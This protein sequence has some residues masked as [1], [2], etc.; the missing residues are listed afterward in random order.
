MFNKK[1]MAVVVLLAVVCA[2]PS[3]GAQFRK[4][5]SDQQF[6]EMCK[7]GNTQGVIEA[8]KSGANVNAE[9]NRD[10][11][12]LIL[13]AVFGHTEIVKALIQ[14]GADINA[15]D[16]LGST[17]LMS[18]RNAEIV[19]ALI[20]AGADVNAKNN[21]GWTALM[22]ATI[23]GNTETVKALIQA[24]ADV[25][26]KNHKGETALM[27]AAWRGR[28]EN[29]NALIE[30]GADDLT[31]NEGRTALIHAAKSERGNPETVNAL[32]EAGSNVKHRDN[33]GKTAVDY[34][35]E[36]DKLKGTDALK[37]LEEL[38]K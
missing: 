2:V 24:G 36:N 30:A 7:E 14:A 11:T 31:D 9:Y 33:S 4:R 3:W 26:A 8:I 32:I 35:R 5:I 19:K 37:R 22:V 16:N 6:L 23:R 28:T 13:A 27:W 38:S 12:A 20:Q 15:K 17:A 34:A 21:D 29:V 25:N 10:L 18:A 1:L